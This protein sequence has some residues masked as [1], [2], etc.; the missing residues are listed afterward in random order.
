MIVPSELEVAALLWDVPRLNKLGAPARPFVDALGAPPWDD[1]TWPETGL[2]PHARA[3]LRARFDGASSASGAFEALCTDDESPLLALLLWSFASDGREAQSAVELALERIG[4]LAPGETRSRL[5]RKVAW[6]ARECGAADAEIGALELALGDAPEGSRLHRAVVAAAV[7]VGLLGVNDLIDLPR[8]EYDPL[9]AVPWVDDVA[10]DASTGVAE[11][12]FNARTRAAWSARFHFGTTNI[13]R[14]HA[15]EL[16]YGW[17]ARQDARNRMRRQLGAALISGA[18]ETSGQWSYGLW[19]WITSGG[20]GLRQLIRIA[21]P[22][23]EAESVAALLES[24]SGEYGLPDREERLLQ[25]TAALWDVVSDATLVDA[26]ENYPVGDANR[27]DDAQHTAL[28]VGVLNRDPKLAIEALEHAPSELQSR[29]LENA[30]PLAAELVDTD[31]AQRLW[32]LGSAVLESAPS[33]AALL[34]RLARRRD[35][36]ASAR[37]WVE[38]TIT[39]VEGLTDVLL[40]SPELVSARGRQT[41]LED[42]LASAM[43]MISTADAGVWGLGGGRSISVLG[44]AAAPLDAEQQAHAAGGLLEVLASDRCSREQCFSALQGLALLATEQPLTTETV[45]AVRRSVADRGRVDGPSID[46]RM[47][48][49]VLHAAATEAMA[50]TLTDDEITRVVVE[51][52]SPQ[53]RVRQLSLRAVGRLLDVRPNEDALVWCLLSGLFDP[54]DEVVQQALQQLSNERL[55]GS[56]AV[57]V[58]RDRLHRLFAERSVPVRSA[59]I[60][61]AHRVLLANDLEPL[62]DGARRDK[63]WVVRTADWEAA[64]FR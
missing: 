17:S 55:S 7:D 43:R 2:A 34:A 63:S 64:R 42:G 21:E 40:D 41:L 22:H 18:A 4:R 57:A 15:A 47:T 19:A 9:L 60:R 26:A 35:G 54:N 25:T 3:F 20:Q 5:A 49:E 36:V 12:Q 8:G 52:R 29:V 13:D 56:T 61:A 10:V 6:H 1:R 51:A 30:W 37:E 24:I 16:Q 14:L 32:S 45:E 44:L 38:A 23:I 33:A 58:A 11:D 53:P 59:V 62:R 27:F 31:A 39:S 50:P 46:D 28:W 48:A